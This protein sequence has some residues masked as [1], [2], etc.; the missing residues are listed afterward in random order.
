MR[1]LKC[2]LENRLDARFCKQCG[3]A[4]QEQ[5]GITP[6]ICP[7]CGATA[8]P[9]AQ[10]CPRC[11]KPLPSDLTQPSLRVADS[12][13]A[14]P[15]TTQPYAAPPSPP[16]PMPPSTHTQPWVPPSSP[17][18][19]TAPER[20]FP[21]WAGCAVAVVVFICVA[22]LVVAAIKF[23]PGLLSSQ[24]E[25]TTTLTPTALPTVEPTPTET[26]TPAPSPSTPEAPLTFDAQVV[27]TASATELQIDAPLAVTV[28]ITNTGQIAFGNLRYQLLGEWEP[29]FTASTDAIADHPVD[30]PPAGSD[31]AIF[32][33]TAMQPGTAQIHANVTVDTREDSPATRPVSSEYVV[34]VLI[35]Q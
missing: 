22:I 18:V 32:V 9:R 8:K 3:Q 23:A 14:M 26:I 12:V 10:F 20:S 27:I 6:T 1:C 13:P 19:P 31:T 5:Q 30:V 2:G 33:L 16:P 29:F 28:T 35:V 21:R 15:S 34:E 7:A 25:P 11:G 4:L 17:S 24:A